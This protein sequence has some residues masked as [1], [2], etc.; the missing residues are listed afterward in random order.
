MRLF[1]SESE[2]STEAPGKREKVPTVNNHHMI[3]DDGQEA[4][5]EAFLVAHEGHT[6]EVE[7]QRGSWSIY[8]HCKRCGEIHTYEVDNEARQQALGLPPWQEEDKEEALF[9]GVRGRGILR[10]W[11]SA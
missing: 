1:G 11:T 9:S 3:G 6:Q 8:C 2:A 5:I 10:N 7:I 4:V